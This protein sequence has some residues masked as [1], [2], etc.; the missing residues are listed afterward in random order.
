VVVTTK[1]EH[2]V[3][4]I[5]DELKAELGWTDGSE[6]V[7]VAEGGEL[8]LRQSD[9]PEPEIYTPERKAEFLLNTAVTEEDYG[10]A[11]AEVRKL[12]IDPATVPHEI[13]AKWSM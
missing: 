4:A 5:P 11:V 1:L 9:L 12:G 7:A 8:R 10:M 13:P 2:G 3:I 6:I